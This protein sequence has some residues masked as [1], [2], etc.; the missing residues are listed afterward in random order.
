MPP[1]YSAEIL[2]VARTL[3]VCK[4]LSVPT[5]RPTFVYPCRPVLGQEPPKGPSL[6]HQ[7]K[8]DGNRLL[9]AKDRDTIRLFSKRGIDW[10]ERLPGLAEAFLELPPLSAVLDG[11][12]CFCD[13]RDRPDFRAL[14]AEMR[15]SRPDVSRMA[16]LCFRP[17]ISRSRR[18]APPV[19]QRAPERFES[20]FAPVD[21]CPAF[22]SGVLSRGRPVA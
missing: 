5:I 11:E 2:S 13:N 12:L 10:T 6:A 20:G 14:H 9:V 1:R 8:W 22:T 3:P 18:F 7:P 16:F 19:V 21:A 17:D 4:P 15:R